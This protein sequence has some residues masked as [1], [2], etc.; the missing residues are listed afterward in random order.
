MKV[1]RLG[2]CAL[3]IG[4]AAPALAECPLDAPGP[5]PEPFAAAPPSPPDPA[6]RPERPSCLAGLSGPEQENCDRAVLAGYAE[7]VDAWVAALND[8]VT[9]TN[10]YANAAA[11]HANAAI[12]HARAARSHAD[13]A[14]A[15]AQCEAAAIAS[16]QGD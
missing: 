16:G 7:A 10:S 4:A 11:I 1:L 2:V 9:A 15:F 8:Y 13:Q 14:L 5:A 6:L 3:S 12:G